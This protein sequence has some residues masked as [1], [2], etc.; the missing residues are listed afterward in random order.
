MT[1]F[2]IDLIIYSTSLVCIFFIL[3]IISDR[4]RGKK[5]SDG[6]EDRIEGFMEL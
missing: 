2:K 6:L 5:W 3:G 4:L 1:N